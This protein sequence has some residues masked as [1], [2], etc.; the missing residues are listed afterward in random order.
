MHGGMGFI[1]PKDKA[2]TGL[3]EKVESTAVEAARRKFSPEFMNRLDKVV[4]FH[5]LRQEQLEQI[6]DIELGRVQQR[7]MDAVSR[8]FRFRLTPAAGAFL[9]CEGTDLKYGARHLKRAIERYVV[10]PLARLVATDQLNTGDMLLIDRQPGD[11]GLSFWREAQ[12]SPRLAEMLLAVSNSSLVPYT[13]A[14]F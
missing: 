7:A 10:N 5:P 12:Q 1:Q 11:K 9:L 6:L 8:R 2:T 3:Y 13:E 4:V 14:G